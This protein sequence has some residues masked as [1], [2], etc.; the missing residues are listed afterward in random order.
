MNLQ[1]MAKRITAGLTQPLQERRD[2]GTEEED[3]KDQEN[4]I[5]QSTPPPPPEQV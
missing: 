4:P 2:Y 1:E 5:P 3:A